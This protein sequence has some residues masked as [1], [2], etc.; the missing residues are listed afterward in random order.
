MIC[1]QPSDETLDE[2]EKLFDRGIHTIQGRESDLFTQHNIIFSGDHSR[3]ELIRVVVIVGN[4]INVVNI[5]SQTYRR[6]RYEVISGI[7]TKDKSEV[8]RLEHQDIRPEIVLDKTFMGWSDYFIN[9]DGSEYQAGGLSDE[10]VYLAEKTSQYAFWYIIHGINKEIDAD[11]IKQ[12][13]VKHFS[14]AVPYKLTIL[15]GVKA[16]VVEKN[17][18]AATFE[19]L[20]THFAKCD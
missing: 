13:L 4:D 7:I 9:P 8:Y 18:E 15:H 19:S 6:V 12:G 3:K 2:I 10:V 17:A 16:L 14:K 1:F 5:S 20:V 11:E